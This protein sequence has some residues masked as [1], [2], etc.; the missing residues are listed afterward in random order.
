MRTGHRKQTFYFSVTK[1]GIIY[2]GKRDLFGI[3]CPLPTRVGPQQSQVPA[4]K[5]RLAAGIQI[6]IRH[7]D[8]GG[9]SGGDDNND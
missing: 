3:N 9:G 5:H 2:Y 1:F 8:N 7:D 4:A 6:I